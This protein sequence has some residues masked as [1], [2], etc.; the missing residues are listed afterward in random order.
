MRPSCGEAE[1]AAFA[2]H[3]AAQFSAVDTHRVVGAVADLL[4]G[5]RRLALT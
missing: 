1:V 3:L 5:S 4:N 2:H